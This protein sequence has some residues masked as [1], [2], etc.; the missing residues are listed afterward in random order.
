ML[1]EEMGQQHLY[2]TVNWAVKNCA[3][4]YCH[5][6]RLDSCEDPAAKVWL[7]D[8]PLFRALIQEAIRR[9]FTFSPEVYGYLQA[10]VVDDVIFEPWADEAQAFQKKKLKKFLK[11]PV[12][13][14]DREFDG[15]V[16]RRMKF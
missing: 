16:L 11:S 12:V 15:R 9:G 7:R 6:L 5:Y 3:R 1:L 2:N 13:K 4:L 14:P 8:Q 10:Y